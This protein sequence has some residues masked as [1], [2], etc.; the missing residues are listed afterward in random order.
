[1]PDHYRVPTS[2]ASPGR[3][4][5]GSGVKVFLQLQ[6]HKPIVITVNPSDDDNSGSETEGSRPEQYMFASL[7]SVSKEAMEAAR[8]RPVPVLEKSAGLDKHRAQ[9]VMQLN[10]RSGK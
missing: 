1:M 9:L 10:N 8:P 2:C 3:G 6:R 4:H 5:P 7:E